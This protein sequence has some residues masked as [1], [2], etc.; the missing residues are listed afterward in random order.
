MK[1]A[2]SLAALYKI[3]NKLNGPIAAKESISAAVYLII[4]DLQQEGLEVTPE[5]IEKR[6][7]DYA[8]DFIEV[9]Q[10]NNAA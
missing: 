5:Q 10:K 9:D 7:S 3:I 4:C 8:Q 2:E 1:T 6:L